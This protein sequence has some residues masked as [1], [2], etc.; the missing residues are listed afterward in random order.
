MILDSAIWKPKKDV[1]VTSIVCPSIPDQI[2]GSCTGNSYEQQTVNLL[3][4]KGLPVQ[5][6]QVPEALKCQCNLSDL[7]DTLQ[8]ALNVNKNSKESLILA[9]LDF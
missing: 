9:K 3:K 1:L 6:D 2:R 5:T 4:R 7:L 8:G